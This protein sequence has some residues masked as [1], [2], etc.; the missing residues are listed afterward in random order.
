MMNEQLSS[1]TW[2]ERV[3]DFLQ[4]IAAHGR[5]DHTITAHQLL[6]ANAPETFAT[7]DSAECF[8]SV[9]RVEIVSDTREKVDVFTRELANLIL[10]APA[11][12]KAD[13]MVTVHDA[14]RAAQETTTAQ[15]AGDGWEANAR[16]LLENCPYSIRVR[17]GGGPENLLSSLVVTFQGMQHKLKESAIA[18]K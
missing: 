15:P 1:K 18:S 6:R 2:N 7:R 14:T 4:Q 17:E 10:D 9:L 13:V 16:Y 3:L 12:N 11:A 5:H 8:E